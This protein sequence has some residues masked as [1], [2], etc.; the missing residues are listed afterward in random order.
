MFFF[1]SGKTA[2][3]FFIVLYW[4]QK[5]WG[6]EDTEE[7]LQFACWE[8]CVSISA[9]WKEEVGE[10]LNCFGILLKSA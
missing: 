5:D 4:R 3:S 8:K 10:K 6:K 2:S 7:N 9:M 1:D